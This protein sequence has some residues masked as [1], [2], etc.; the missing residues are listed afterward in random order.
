MSF[1]SY[2]Y[3]LVFFQFAIIF[4]FS[5]CNYNICILYIFNNYNYI[6]I[7]T[8]T[9]T[10]T[11]TYIYIYLS[12]VAQSCSTLCDLMSAAHQ[13]SLSI[14]NSRSLLKLMSI[15]SVMP[16]KPSSVIPF[17]S[18]IQSFPASGSVPMISPSHQVAKELEFQLHHQSF[19]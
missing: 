6:Y 2:C 10:H 11:H 3:E 5:A 14:T 9:Y 4:H 1:S 19:Q 12:S 15:E 16:S 13:A 18:C 17:S 7:Y 8:Y